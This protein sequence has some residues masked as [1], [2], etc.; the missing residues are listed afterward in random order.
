MRGRE[1]GERREGLK[2]RKKGKQGRRGKDEERKG[3]EREKSPGNV[4]GQGRSQTTPH[5]AYYL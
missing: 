5:L 4:V 3:R 2:K 1:R